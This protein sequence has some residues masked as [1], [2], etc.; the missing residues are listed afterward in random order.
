M[1]TGAHISSSGTADAMFAESGKPAAK[2]CK[3]GSSEMI[4][5]RGGEVGRWGGEHVALG[6]V[7]LFLCR[8]KG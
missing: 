1:A 6:R 5:R 3:T 4:K 2:L 8:D 7:G